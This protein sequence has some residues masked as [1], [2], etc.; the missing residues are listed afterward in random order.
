MPKQL[1][2]RQC[3]TDSQ[4]AKNADAP[5]QDFRTCF[6]CH[7]ADSDGSMQGYYSGLGTPANPA[8]PFHGK[9]VTGANVAGPY[10][11]YPAAN[12]RGAFNLFHSSYGGKTGMS[13]APGNPGNEDY[14]RNILNNGDQYF[15]LG[16]DY[17]N[18]EFN[19]WSPSGPR[20]VSYTTTTINEQGSNH[21]IPVFSNIGGADL[22][23]SCTSCHVDRSSLVACDN[24]NWTNHTGVERSVED[25]AE[26]TYLGGTCA[27]A[28]GGGGTDTTAPTVSSFTLPASNSMK[29]PGL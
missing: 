2:C 26:T 27:P 7:A 9:N 17:T 24:P 11:A 20:V 14:H 29:S 6:D 19:Y 1:A 12:G 21:T 23:N 8:I 3:H 4:H 15:E 22:L 5:I 25:L 18:T 10:A 16:V 13:S 28:G